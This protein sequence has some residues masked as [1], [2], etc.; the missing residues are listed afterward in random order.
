MGIDSEII[1]KAYEDFVESGEDMNSAE[2]SRLVSEL[3]VRCR[4]FLRHL[5]GKK[6]SMDDVEDVLSQSIVNMYKSIGLYVGKCPFEYWVMSICRNTFYTFSRGFINRVDI[7]KVTCFEDGGRP[8]DYM[9]Y[10]ILPEH[11]SKDLFIK[12]LNGFSLKDI[13]EESGLCVDTVKVR[14]FRYR[15]LIKKNIKNEACRIS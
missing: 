15:E 5:M 4:S 1:Q 8:D 13:S 11:N 7:D 14:L 2:F 6:Y 3:R 12:K 9:I 10:D